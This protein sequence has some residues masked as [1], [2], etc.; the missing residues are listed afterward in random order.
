[1]AVA[2]LEG[3]D[4]YPNGVRSHENRYGI[5]RRSATRRQLL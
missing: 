1:M 4:T 2:L 5:P 3:R